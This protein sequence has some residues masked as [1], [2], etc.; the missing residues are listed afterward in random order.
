MTTEYFETNGFS[1]KISHDFEVIYELSF[2]K[3]E[4]SSL[5]P[6]GESV[7]EQLA[8]Y[9]SGKRKRFDLKYVAKGTC[10]REKVWHELEKIPYGDTISY[11]EL[12]RR[13]GNPAATRAVGGACHNNP[14][15]II[16]PCHRVIGKDG[17]LTGYGG[18][19]CNKKRL[20][21][22]EKTFS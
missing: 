17:E 2:E 11:G 15:G 1:I 19:L 14:V 16:V 4:S 18:G 12:A 8:E 9:F 5:S 6:F 13:I 10:F 20:I 3:G 21:D 7:K 22:I